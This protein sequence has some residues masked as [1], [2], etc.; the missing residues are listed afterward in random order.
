MSRS[1][2]T[3]AALAAALGLALVASIASGHQLP[4]PGSFGLEVIGENPAGGAPGILT[5]V[6][7]SAPAIPVGVTALSL[8]IDLTHNSG[9]WQTPLGRVLTP[10]FDGVNP[11][12]LVGVP[13]SAPGIG[14]AFEFADYRAGA[15]PPASTAIGLGF[16]TAPYDPLVVNNAL[17][18]AV[19]V[20]VNPPGFPM[21][22][23]E[24][25][26]PVGAGA[27]PFLNT[28]YACSGNASPF[29]SR[30]F[31]DPIQNLLVV[32]E[33][34]QIETFPLGFTL[35]P[36]SAP[37]AV[38]VIPAPLNGAG[39][40]FQVGTNGTAGFVGPLGENMI[41]GLR[42]PAGAAGHGFLAF[43]GGVAG[44]T[45]FSGVDPFGA[46][47]VLAPGF[48]EIALSG[49][50]PFPVATFL[51][52][53][54]PVGILGGAVGQV[55]LLGGAITPVATVCPSPFGDPEARRNALGD[56]VL[57]MA[58]AAAGDVVGAIGT[59]ISNPLASLAVSAALPGFIV[60]EQSDRPISLPIVG[61]ISE[62]VV[63]TGAIGT[64]IG[65]VLL[66]VGPGPGFSV[67][68]GFTSTSTTGATTL[69]NT[70]TGGLLGA[71]PIFAQG[72]S[73]SGAPSD[74]LVLGTPLGTTSITH[75][76]AFVATPIPTLGALTLVPP[77]PAAPSPSLGRR[78]TFNF[79]N[80][81]PTAPVMVH[82]QHIPGV[83]S[84]LVVETPGVP[85]AT[86]AF[87]TVNSIVT[88][89]FSF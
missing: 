19:Y 64:L 60:P 35:P 20:A 2:T 36:F 9:V 26:V 33:N 22:V 79:A 55:T 72:F 40:Q 49:G 18:N 84:A 69:A 61:P 82:P 21:F 8:P 15:A 28:I 16:G 80:G 76:P 44:V 4:S 17:Y 37:A 47:L 87:V 38:N 58:T 46:G 39:V 77:N 25:Q 68:V 27:A 14:L 5:V 74:L 34:N 48:H 51:A 50:A 41:I 43:S 52:D 57:F 85:A 75:F 53:N 67:P 10:V 3:R 23:V 6:A 81:L 54:L 31:V 65:G 83:V 30:M 71:Q 56:P 89:T 59:G 7:D 24:F 66:K 29:V 13:T 86:V 62:V 45:T 78:T 32:P 11:L 42:S 88:E 73:F 70:L 12:P 1:K 63:S